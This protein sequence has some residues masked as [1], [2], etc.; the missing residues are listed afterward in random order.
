MLKILLDN[1]LEAC[2]CHFGV[3]KVCVGLKRY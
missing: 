2:V 3:E 1:A